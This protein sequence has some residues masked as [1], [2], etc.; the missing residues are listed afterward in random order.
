MRERKAILR[1]EILNLRNLLSKDEVSQKSYEI[2]KNLKS[3]EEY[4]SGRLIMCYVD[5]NNEVMTKA[6][7]DQSIEEGKR[8]LVP[9]IAD[10][11]AGKKEMC[12]AEIASVKSDLE[13]GAYGILEPKKNNLK[14]VEPS[15]IDLVVVP[16]V[17]F[18]TDGHR[19]GYGA[20]Y[21]DRFLKKLRSGCVKVGVAFEI[22]VLTQIPVDKH[23]VPVE[24][25]ITENGIITTTAGTQ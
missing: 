19:I 15:E 2:I 13:P 21:Y 4:K 18:N 6:F 3:L 25:L 9:A 16:G 7:I 11:T 24:I 23:D 1:K 12:A 5:F 17:V 10:T 20:G 14:K 22:Q 8:I